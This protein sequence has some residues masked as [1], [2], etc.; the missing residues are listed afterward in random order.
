VF[1]ARWFFLFLP[2]LILLTAVGVE[3]KKIFS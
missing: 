2:H 1:P 3:F